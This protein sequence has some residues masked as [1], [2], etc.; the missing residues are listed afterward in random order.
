MRRVVGLA[1]IA[2][3]MAC[4]LAARADET[5]Y[6]PAKVSESLKAIFQFGSVAT[7]LALNANTDFRRRPVRAGGIVGRA[8]HD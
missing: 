2:I 5:E 1:I 7:K 6:D 4:G 3:M 8:S